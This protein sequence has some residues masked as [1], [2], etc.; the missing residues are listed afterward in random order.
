MNSERCME[1]MSRVEG[2]IE[3]IHSRASV[4]A[5]EAK[6]VPRE[7]IERLLEAAVRAPNHRLTEPW[8]F[9]VLQGESKRR[10][11]ELRREHRA[12]KFD[13]PTAPEVERALE[14]AYDDVVR[15]PAVI[16]VTAQVSDDRVRREEDYAATCCAIQNLLLAAL[17]FGLGTYWR[18]GALIEDP[19]LLD[20]LGASSEE[21]VVGA[22]Y[23]GYP[24][25]APKPRPRTP[26]AEVTRWLE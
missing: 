7:T 2:I 20:L 17:S 1:E 13:D 19:R 6:P 3:A 24:A 14:K 5:F 8:R 22:I 10:F 11:A 9:Y 21:R 16:T 15:T 12:A 25:D 4:K 18:T 26:A 23:L